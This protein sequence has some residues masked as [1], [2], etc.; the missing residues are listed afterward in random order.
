MKRY[1]II[2]TALVISCLFSS[3][4][5]THARADDLPVVRAV[6]FYSRTCGHCEYV[7]NET[8]APMIE[9]YGEQLQIIAIDVTQPSGQ[10]LLRPA[11][12]KFGLERSGV[13]FLVFDDMYLIGS[14]DIPEKFPGLVET[15]L[16]QGG[17]DWPDI[18][19]LREAMAQSSE[20]YDPTATSTAQSA[21]LQTTP[22]PAT[23]TSASA[24]PLA[25]PGLIPP[26]AH[27]IDWKDNF[28]HDLTSNTL[29][30]VVLAGMLA[31][32]ALAV[33][34]FHRTNSVSLKGGWARV[35]PILCLF[36]FCVAGYLAY[37]ET[38]Q[39]TAVCGPVGDCNTVQQSEYARLF[40]I[41]PIGALGLM[42]YATMIVAWFVARNADDGLS[43]FAAIALF[44]M[45][46]FGT[47]FSLYLTF[48]E[49]F[50]IGATC[51]WCLTSAILMTILMLLTVRPAKTA[52]SRRA[53]PRPFHPKNM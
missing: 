28:T 8:L 50:I 10:E 52:F 13:P 12:Q 23:A 3:I 48:L 4:T 20:P 51:A 29:A 38:A 17:L 7:I 9:K 39:V 43:D 6:L 40:G 37:V 5:D 34:L 53:Q 36:G 19:G 31:S 35:T 41:L 16:A 15:Y 25:T 44:G 18:P 26:S 49:P 32:L 45:A 27:N 47:L 14:V 2:I 24:S 22:A 42:G 33:L 11:L 21:V 46:T 1:C 30:V